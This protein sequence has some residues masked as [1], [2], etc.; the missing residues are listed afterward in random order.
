MKI[1]FTPL[2]ELQIDS[3]H[4]YISHNAS[5]ERADAY[6]SRIAAFCGGSSTSRDAAPCVT[7]FCRDY[8]SSGSSVVSPLRS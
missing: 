6:V 1:V 3:L 4:A 7:I 5:E 8:G 2:A